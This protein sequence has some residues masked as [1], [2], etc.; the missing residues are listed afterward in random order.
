MQAKPC[1]CCSATSTCQP[2]SKLWIT[3]ERVLSLLVHEE[4]K[5]DDREAFLDSIESAQPEGQPPG[6]RVRGTVFAPMMARSSS[7]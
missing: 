4:T 1:D 7:C 3:D 5:A 2:R 6:A